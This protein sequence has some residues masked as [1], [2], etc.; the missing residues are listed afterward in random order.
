ME[1]KKIN[2]FYFLLL[3][4]KN[5]LKC[6]NRCTKNNYLKEQNSLRNKYLQP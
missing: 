1:F 3:L 5:N 6:K 4:F 2:H